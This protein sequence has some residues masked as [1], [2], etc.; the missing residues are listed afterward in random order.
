[1]D[2]RRR[3]RVVNV[4]VSNIRPQYDNLKE[5]CADPDNI[6]IGRKGVVFIDGERYPKQDSFWANPYKVGRDGDTD[7]VMTKFMRHLASNDCYLARIREL[8]DKNLGCWCHP[9]PCH[10]HVLRTL[11]NMVENGEIEQRTSSSE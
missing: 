2:F 11:L 3:T 1:M 9:K 8:K 4:R 5:W 7:E 6:Y 10:G